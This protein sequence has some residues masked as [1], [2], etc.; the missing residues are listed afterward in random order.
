MEPPV[1]QFVPTAL[2]L[3]IRCHR[4]EPSSHRAGIW[5]WALQKCKVLGVLPTVVSGLQGTASER[6]QNTEQIVCFSLLESFIWVPKFPFTSEDLLFTSMHYIF[7]TLKLKRRR[8][9]MQQKLLTHHWDMYWRHCKTCKIR[10]YQHQ[11]CFQAADMF[12]PWGDHR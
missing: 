9:E 2:C 5:V 12:L 7:S 10:E 4:G 3:I 1:I 11:T 8:K 6:W